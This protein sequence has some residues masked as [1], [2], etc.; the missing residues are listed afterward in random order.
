MKIMSKWIALVVAVI[1]L[2]AAS[3]AHAQATRTWV[4]GVGDDVNPCSRTAPC[5]TFAGAISKTA[6]GGEIDCLDPGGFGAVTITKSITIDCHETMGGILS[7]STSG[8]I[9]NGAGAIVVLRGLVIDGGPPTPSPGLNGVRFVLGASLVIED[10]VLQNSL[11][12]SATSGWGISF[13]PS[14]TS[15]L[16][17][18]NTLIHNNG[19][20]TNGGGILIQ[21]TGAAGG[22]RVDIVNSRIENNPFQGIRV[23][24]VSNPSAADTMVTINGTTISGS[25]LGSG[26][27]VSTPIGGSDVNVNV[28]SSVISGNGNGINSNGN[29]AR[30]AVSDTLLFNNNTAIT[31]IGGSLVQSFGN[32]RLQLNAAGNA[33]NLPNLTPQ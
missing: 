32:N 4:S 17:V 33:F 10:C 26:L 1:W 19:G 27:V 8:V 9:V 29:F 3:T 30:V 12:T 16:F 31:S 7:A 25:I 11:S 15:R 28:N 6:A 23:D 18:S 20:A 5:K 22:A 2:G 13:Q 24:T 21:P 14:G